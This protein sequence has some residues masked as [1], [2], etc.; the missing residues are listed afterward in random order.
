MTFNGSWIWTEENLPEFNRFVRF[1]KNFTYTDGKADLKITADTRYILYINGE[2]LGYGPGRCWANHYNYDIYD[3]SPYLNKG[4]NVIAVLVN[5]YNTSTFQYVSTPEGLICDLFLDNEIVSSDT[6]FKVKKDNCFVNNTIRV[7][8]QQGFEEIY[9]ASGD[10]NWKNADYDDSDWDDAIILRPNEDGIH[11]NFEYKNIPNLTMETI[12]PKRIV[13]AE[14]VRSSDYFINLNLKEAI[15]PNNRNSNFNTANF[16]IATQITSDSDTKGILRGIFQGIKLFV[17]GTEYPIDKLENNEEWGAEFNLNKGENDF[18]IAFANSNH[19]INF[20]FAIDCKEN[21]TFSSGI[22]KEKYA[23]I[24]PFELTPEQKDFITKYNDPEDIQNIFYG[25]QDKNVSYKVFSEFIKKPLIDRFINTEYYNEISGNIVPEA[26]PFNISYTDSKIKNISV[27]PYEYLVGNNTWTTVEPDESGDVR[28][29]L[30]YGQ[31]LCGY[32][33]FELV[34]E[35]NVIVDF[36]NFEFI[37]PDG[38]Y[39]FAEGMTNSFRYI[40]KEGRQKYQTLLRRGFRYTYIT[41]RNLKRPLKIRNINALYASYQ[42]NN[43]GSFVC[44]DYKLNKIWEIGANTM[45]ACAEDTYVDCPTYEQTL[46]VGDARNESLVDFAVNG[47]SRLWLRWLRITGQ[48]IERSRITESEVPSGWQNILPAWTFLWMRSCVEYYRYTG[49]TENTKDLISY[50]IKNAEGIKYYINDLGLFEI[51]AWNMFDWAAM[52]TPAN[53]ATITHN[54]CFAVLALNETAEI[55]QELGYEKEAKE[56]KTMAD[57]LK[58]SINKYMWNEEKQAYT[59]CIRGTEQSAI[60][61][62]QTHTV[63]FMSGVAEGDR[64]IRS[65]EILYNPPE[66][67]VKA[68]SPFYE[69]FLLEALQNDN[70][71][72]EFLD[73]IRRDWGFMADKG[74]TA[75]WEMWSCGTK[76]GDRLT[77][78]HCH[79]WSSAPTFFLS[80]FVLGIKP[81]KPGF[82]EVI[83]A[84]HF[85]D[86]DWAR[87]TFP[88]PKGNIKV[89]WKKLKNG[90]YDIKVNSPVPYELITE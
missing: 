64:A 62:Q 89:S 66:G 53:G 79:G 7:S 40:T 19:Y 22:G 3:I 29:L 72:Q 70:R 43:Q 44:S 61:S 60:F 20:Q 81:K 78:S 85:G 6:S 82:E 13:S 36:H 58:F 31:A 69:F 37:Q 55:A 42:Q 25:D 84:P 68:G 73:I 34:S 87:G 52:D 75:F 56:W 86:L 74:A 11:N 12:C 8:C 71:P 80:S 45:R 35:E 51:R 88:T 2:Y 5:H 59:D 46:W 26:S 54:N 63:A 24:G 83:I 1:R 18:I 41:F 90:S 9:N 21:L 30:D 33:T 47:D 10:D 76:E 39:N 17:N 15:F 38:R 67:F 65:K 28:V 49:D 32:Q 27:K 23:L 14:T 50:L 16:C 4:N 57:S 77:R 48:S